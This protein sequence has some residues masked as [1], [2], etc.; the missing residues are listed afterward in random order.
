MIPIMP[1]VDTKNL[2]SFLFT[3]T[4]VYLLLSAYVIS[5][6]IRDIN[7]LGGS[8]TKGIFLFVLTFL[9]IVAILIF[10]RIIPILKKK[11]MLSD[12]FLEEQ[13]V[14]QVIDQD[15]KLLQ[16]KIME[17]E[18]NKRINDWNKKPN[19]KIEPFIWGNIKGI[20]KQAFDKDF[21]EKIYS[22]RILK[23]KKKND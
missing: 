17:N 20:A 18:E 19:G 15:F 9:A 23:G 3:F 4:I 2:T 8:I 10:V 13:I 16:M 6:L 14:H 11:E 21:Y 22:Y 7:N 12:K 1:Q 5:I